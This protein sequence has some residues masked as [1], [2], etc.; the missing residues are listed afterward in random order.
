MP[1]DLQ[2][3]HQNS[4]LIVQ[5]I[6]LLARFALVGD[7]DGVVPA[8]TAQFTDPVRRCFSVKICPPGFAYQI[9]KGFSMLAQGPISIP[10][11]SCG[12][13]VLRLPETPLQKTNRSRMT[14]NGSHKIRQ[15]P[16]FQVIVVAVDV[17]LGY[18]NR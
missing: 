6:L 3:H 7:G 10:Q 9:C 15:V 18:L 11:S 13:P 17:E 1:V 14:K 16:R 5:G 12:E 4:A 8:K 2:F